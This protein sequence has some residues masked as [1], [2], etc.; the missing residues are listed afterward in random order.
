MA[1]VRA[2]A[3][4]ASLEFDGARAWLSHLTEL[5]LDPLAADAWVFDRDL[6]QVLLIQHPWRGWVPPG[7]KVEPGETPRAAAGRELFEETGVRAELL[8][9]P[10][11][12]R[13]RSYRRDWAPT[14]NLTYVAVV[15]R[16]VPLRPEPDQPAAWHALDLPW[17]GWFADDRAE[18][19]AYAARLQP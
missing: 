6:S 14:L 10:A 17:D 15:D 4:R 11:A 3:M 19:A 18:I 2:D 7:G 1:S 12:V 16:E 13:I 5:Q 8:E 9:L